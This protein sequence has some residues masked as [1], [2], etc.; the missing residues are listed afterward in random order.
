MRSVAE[1]PNEWIVNSEHLLPGDRIIVPGGLM[2][3]VESVL[4]TKDSVVVLMTDERERV[5]T[6]PTVELVYRRT[7]AA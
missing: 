1:W 6:R 2:A 4:R 5:Y 3:P 7:G